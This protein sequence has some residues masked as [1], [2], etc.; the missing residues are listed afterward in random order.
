MKF[1]SFL[2]LLLFNL[3]FTAVHGIIS[4]DSSEL[5]RQPVFQRCVRKIS[6]LKIIKV[7]PTV[8]FKNVQDE[9]VEAVDITIN[10]TGNEV[11][12]LLKVESRSI[13]LFY[14]C[15]NITDRKKVSVQLEKDSIYEYF[16][17]PVG[18]GNPRNS[19]AAIIPLTDS[20]LLLAW[21]EFYAGSDE[22]HGPAQI[23]GKISADGGRT[24]GEKYVLIR[25]DG[26]CNVMEVNFLR[27]RENE[28]ALFY[29]QKNTESSDCRI[30]MR[31]S[32]D[33]GKS[34]INPKQLSPAG[35][36]TGLT[37]GRSI[38]LGSGRILLE[39]W[40]GGYCYCILSDDNG[41]TWHDS[42][43]IKPAGGECYESACIELNNGNVMM[44]MR[45][46]LGGQF[47]SISYDA[48]ESWSAPVITL[49]TGTP[50]PVSISRIPGTGDLLAIWTH[51]PGEN[52]RNPL[53]SAISRDEAETWEHFRNLEDSP[54]D[55]WAYPAVTWIENRA[56]ITYFSYKGGYSLKLK[57]LP[58]KW[59][60]N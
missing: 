57:S 17:A 28:I 47:K 50:A 54:D 20:T 29:C 40:T 39:A 42:K 19:E 58:V 41:N 24:W 33:E 34:W 26:G 45:T 27:L 2:P 59:F 52:K 12:G 35:R 22:D 43:Y 21:T 38:R 23:S 46:G 25:N 30:M 10:N 32:F 49:L 51:N 31:T 56:L 44:L 5:K 8:F 9:L 36:Y 53:T 13:T 48:G 7:D 3:S 55:A 1:L 15:K 14:G 11:A 18:P 4:Y 60:Y 16:I 37:N 6:I